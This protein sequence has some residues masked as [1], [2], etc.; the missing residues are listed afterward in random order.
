MNIQDLHDKVATVTNNGVT[1]SDIINVEEIDNNGVFHCTL[2]GQII[3]SNN[4]EDTYPIN[5]LVGTKCPASFSYINDDT[6]DYCRH[7]VD[8]I[9]LLNSF[10]VRF[11]Y[12]GVIF[13]NINYR[14]GLNLEESSVN[15][16]CYQNDIN[17]KIYLD[18]I[19]LSNIKVCTDDQS[20]NR[21]QCTNDVKTQNVQKLLDQIFSKTPWF[22]FIRA[23]FN[24][25]NIELYKK[26]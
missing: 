22:D 16:R 23:W 21:K 4:F 24:Y 11:K 13:Y 18:V 25:F 9:V 12:R 2:D 26:L 10:D 1:V 14:D 5:P 20:V 19:A 17:Q 15:R 7:T 3:T 6:D 8:T